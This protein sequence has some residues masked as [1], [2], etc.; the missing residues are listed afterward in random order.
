MRARTHARTHN[1]T[2]THAH[3]RTRECPPG[4]RQVAKGVHRLPEP[5]SDAD[6]DFDD[7]AESLLLPIPGLSEIRKYV[8]ARIRDSYGKNCDSDKEEGSGV[9]CGCF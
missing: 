8:A 9:W 5:T 1:T 2:H 6:G 4:P 7:D 3:A